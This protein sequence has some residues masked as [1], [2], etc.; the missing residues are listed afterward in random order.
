M[1]ELQD[2]ELDGDET[3]PVLPLKDALWAAATRVKDE[4]LDGNGTH[5]PILDFM[6]MAQTL[7][8]EN[9]VFQESNRANIIGI[10]KSVPDRKGKAWV[11]YEEGGQQG[12]KEDWKELDRIYTESVMKQPTQTMKKVNEKKQVY[13][14][15]KCAEILRNVGKMHEYA[16]LVKQGLADLAD[17]IDDVS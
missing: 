13:I 15:Q 16:A 1:K 9:K 12:T 4:V 17:Q 2:S 7:F 8:Y 11:N 6:L 3:K 14:Q 10:M 5:I